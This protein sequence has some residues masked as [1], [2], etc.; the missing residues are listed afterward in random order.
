MIF[1]KYF[2][3]FFL[4]YPRLSFLYKQRDLSSSHLAMLFAYILCEKSQR[5]LLQHF[6]NLNYVAKVNDLSIC[7]LKHTHTRSHCTHTFY[8]FN[9]SV[10][11]HLLLLRPQIFLFMDANHLWQSEKKIHKKS[12]T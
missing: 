5:R 12:F 9:K 11:L 6:M 3:F 4:L 2:D 7:K 8:A 1:Y 10:Y